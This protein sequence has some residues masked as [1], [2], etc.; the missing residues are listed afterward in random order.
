MTESKKRGIS[1]E[2]ARKIRQDKG[3]KETNLQ[4][5]R[6]KRGLSQDDLA[7]VSG[8]PKRRIQTYEQ[9]TRL[10]EGA[11]LDVLCSLSKALNCKIE[12]ILDD[13]ELI[14]QYKAIK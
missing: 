12:H 11:R 6:I 3:I 4:K 9:R 8:V 10:I 14:K 1:V 2:T 13:K 7:A 5:I